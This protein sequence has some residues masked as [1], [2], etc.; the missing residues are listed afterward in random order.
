MKE[1]VTF[2]TAKTVELDILISVIA[3]EVDHQKGKHPAHG[4][5][6]D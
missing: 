5:T 6:K 2:T 1:I 3:E 4:D